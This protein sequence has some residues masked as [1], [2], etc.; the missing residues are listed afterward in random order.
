LV[1]ASGGPAAAT[2]ADVFGW[3]AAFGLVSGLLAVAAVTLTVNSL[4][5][6]KL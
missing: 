5:S 3:S 2:L 4:F 1:G 6:V